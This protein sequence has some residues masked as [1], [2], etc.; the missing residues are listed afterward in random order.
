[1]V[2]SFGLALQRAMDADDYSCQEVADCLD[3]S[4]STISNWRNDQ[5][6]TI[7]HCRDLDEFFD[8]PSGYFEEYRYEYFN[9]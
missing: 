3:L 2:T 8:K 7:E 1:M 5:I 4:A 6:P 9:C